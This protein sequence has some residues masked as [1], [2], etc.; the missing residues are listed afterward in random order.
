MPF[1]WAEHLSAFHQTPK[2]TAT[3]AAGA[4]ATPVGAAVTATSAG[5]G[6]RTPA[7]AAAV[8]GVATAAAAAGPTAAGARLFSLC[9]EASFLFERRGVAYFSG[10]TSGTKVGR[11]PVCFL[12]RAL[13]WA[14]CE[15]HLC[16]EGVFVFL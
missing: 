2:A 7:A 1:W 3:T 4:A 14:L 5:A 6:A 16:V 10:A 11:G 12:R 15:Q 9:A 13:G 8:T